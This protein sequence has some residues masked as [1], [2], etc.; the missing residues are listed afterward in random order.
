MYLACK[1]GKSGRDPGSLR[2]TSPFY[3]PSTGRRPAASGAEK[4]SG[5]FPATAL[6]HGEEEGLGLTKGCLVSHQV[7]FL[8]VS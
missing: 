1:G 5:I 6:C 2:D 3:S 8:S 4:Q 7:T